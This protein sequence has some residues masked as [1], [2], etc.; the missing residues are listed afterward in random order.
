MSKSQRSFVGLAGA[1][2]LPLLWLSACK[3]PFAEKRSENGPINSYQRMMASEK[4]LGTLVELRAGLAAYAKTKGHYPGKLEDIVG[5]GGIQNIPML[6]LE[7]H[8]DT[9]DVMNYGD[10]VCVGSHVSG[11]NGSKLNDSGKWGYVSD[12]AS[13]CFGI[14]FID[15]AHLHSE[16]KRYWWEY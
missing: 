4:S 5:A 9:R 8:P 13:K 2:V 14:V 6:V 3:N 16:S 12:P 10:E 7:D 15:C 11:S 1:L